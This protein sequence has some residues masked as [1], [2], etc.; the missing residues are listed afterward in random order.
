[1]TFLAALPAWFHWL[2]ST[3]F[4]VGIRQGD[5]L[6]P[7]IEGSHILALS[8]SV[9]LIVMLDLRLLRLAFRGEAVSKVMH[10]IMPWALPGFA[11]MFVTGIVLFITQA[12]K[13]YTN[14]FFRFKILFLFLAGVNALFYQLKFYPHMQEWD[15]APSVPMGARFTAVVS[16]CLWIAIIALGRTMAYE[17]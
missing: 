1:M 17:L 4:A 14:T 12:E 16:L 13:A 10:Q 6:F 3:P 15:T 9:G 11:V 7:F 5:L 8:F 2:Q